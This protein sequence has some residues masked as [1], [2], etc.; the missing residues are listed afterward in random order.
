MRTPPRSSSSRDRD[1]TCTTEQSGGSA[2]RRMS[3]AGRRHDCG[4]DRSSG[5]TGPALGAAVFQHGPTSAG[6]HPGAEAVALGSPV[7]VG[8]KCALHEVLLGR[9]GVHAEPVAV[10]SARRYAAGA[11]PSARAACQGY[12]PGERARQ[13]KRRRAGAARG[14]RF[15]AAVERATVLRLPRGGG[16]STPVDKRVD[17]RAESVS[18]VR[19]AERRRGGG[20]GREV[21]RLI[22]GM[23]DRG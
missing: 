11:L 16:L 8:L 10:A 12:R 5:E 21:G 1:T 2:R 17:V 4:S 23:E 9:S 3:N 7:V 6:R 15:G 13:T 22:R 20:D 19:P 18:G 14:L